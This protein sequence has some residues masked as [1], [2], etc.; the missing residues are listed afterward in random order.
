MCFFFLFPPGKRNFAFPKGKCSMC[1]N[2]LIYY[3][4]GE[5]RQKYSIKK[6]QIGQRTGLCSFV[7]RIGHEVSKI[8]LCFPA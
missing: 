2:N 1:K 7:N 6:N 3:N 5:K 4:I 8:S